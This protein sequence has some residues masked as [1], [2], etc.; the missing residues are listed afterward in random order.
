MPLKTYKEGRKIGFD[1][2]RKA[3]IYLSLQK[4][5]PIPLD[6]MD[7]DL[8][9]AAAARLRVP[10]YYNLRDIQLKQA[11]QDMGHTKVGFKPSRD[12]RR[13]ELILPQ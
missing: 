13:T 2:G 9:R 10:Q 5:V 12:N 1:K 8:L 3:G 4:I 7:K 11:I 6:A